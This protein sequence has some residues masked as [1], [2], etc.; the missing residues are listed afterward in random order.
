MVSNSIPQNPDI[1]E[2]EIKVTYNEDESAN[3]CPPRDFLL[4]ARNQWN[5]SLIG[6]FIGGSFSFKFVREQ[7]LKL[8]SN[9]GLT[10][11]YYSSKCYFTFRFN[12]LEERNNIL[13]LNSVQI[14]GKTV[15]NS[16]DGGL[17]LQT[18]CC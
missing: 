4:N 8:W 18:K 11:V 17:H 2:S 12:T 1:I 10:R 9:L 15:S 6:H 13:G 7:A 16:L 14:G 3:I 5:I